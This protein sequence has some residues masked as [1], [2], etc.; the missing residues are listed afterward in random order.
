MAGSGLTA[1]L[2]LLQQG[3]GAVAAPPAL[4]L[5][6]MGPAAIVVF[7]LAY[8]AVVLENRLHLRKSK[9]VV[10]GAGIIWALVALVY[11]RAGDHA[12]AAAAVRHNL[13]EFSELFLFVLVAMTY[14]N[15][16]EER[17][18][19]DAL[20]AWLARRNLTLRAV[21]WATGILSFFLSAMIDNLTTA[22]VMGTVAL[23]VGK[24]SRKFMG[25]ACINIV[26]A[27]NAGGAFSPFGDITTLMVWQSGKVEFWQFFRLFLPAVVNWLVP[28]LIMS[29]AVP[30]ERPEGDD[31]RVQVRPG[32]FVIVGLFA[33]TVA[34]AVTFYNALYIP[35][36][37]GMTTGLGLLY[38][39]SWYLKWTGG[40][41][42]SGGPLEVLDEEGEAPPEGPFDI[43]EILQRAEW[44]TL[45]FFFGIIMAIGGLATLGYLA[46]LSGRL[47]SGLGTVGANTSVGVISAV[48][49]NIPVMF[50]VLRM[51][52][53]MTV[54][55]WLLVT[56]TAGVGGSLLS[57]GSA[58]GVA[59]MGQARG[60]YTF[61]SH[62]KWTWAIALGFAASIGVHLLVNGV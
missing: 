1:F 27:A 32:G 25:M 42:S 61:E 39:Y 50:S 34:T 26:V 15:T 54:P 2:A 20:R 57:V 60:I 44:D 36:V 22:L 38:F 11:V 49:D 13:A 47:Y 28:A 48:V 12:G 23:T 9:P 16:M 51:N 43:F 45:M 24:Q 14:V 19:F 21:F 31:A 18:V 53:A 56:L 4:A 41:I 8:V 3:E 52:P 6:W 35:P 33:V 59:L 58:A 62:L 30:K 5:T 29:F 7:V 10:L 46:A 40:A 17:L 55:E 37:L